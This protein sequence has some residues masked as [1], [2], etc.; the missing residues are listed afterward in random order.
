MGKKDIVKPR[1]V[2]YYKRFQVK[3]QRRRAGKTD[4]RARLRLINQDKNKYNSPKY[5]FVVRFSNKY[6]LCQVIYATIGGDITMCQA[7][8]KE[9][10]RYGMKAGFGNYSAAYCTGLLCARRLL[11]KVGLDEEYEGQTEVNGEVYHVESSGE[12]RPFKVLLDT[13]LART[14][15]GA[16]VFGAMKGAADGGLDIPHNE[17]RFPGYDKDSKELDADIHNGY[18]HGRHVAEYAETL[19]EEEPETYQKL[20]ASYL[21]N[22]FTPED[23]EEA[24]EAVI[25]A[26]RENPDH[27]PTEKKKPSTPKTWKLPKLT[28]EQRKANLKEKLLALKSLS[29]GDED[30]ED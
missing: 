7:N 26:I 28:Y 13:G 20:F 12:K 27:V 1:S 29:A 5:R 8:S 18:I 11:K 2:Q 14:S 15:T 25:E 17:K 30:E 16:R 21:E 6:V 4:Y 10:E 22:D 23:M 24:M 9:L 3:Y 19:H